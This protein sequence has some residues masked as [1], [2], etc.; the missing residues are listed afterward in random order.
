MN[1]K[2]IGEYTI[3]DKN[4]DYVFKDMS[5]DTDTLFLNGT[6]ELKERNKKGSF[7]INFGPTN[8]LENDYETNY[9]EED[10]EDIYA[11]LSMFYD[12]FDIKTDV[13]QTG[14]DITIEIKM[15]YVGQK[16]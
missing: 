7:K 10:D 6:V 2:I 8:Q 13:I 9:S 16:Q 14:K 1:K 5:I 15:K 3:K 4:F 12:S 11:V